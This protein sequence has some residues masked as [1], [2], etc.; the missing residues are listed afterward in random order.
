MLADDNSFDFVNVMQRKTVKSP[1]I[2]N[3]IMK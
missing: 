3:C 2:I 1:D